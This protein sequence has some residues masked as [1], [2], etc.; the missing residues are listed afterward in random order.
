MSRWYIKEK[1]A[2]RGVH[3]LGV[4]KEFYLWRI[5]DGGI[6]TEVVAEIYD[7]DRASQICEILNKWEEEHPDV[8]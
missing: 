3:A 5:D 6:I 8:V 4:V 7:Q 1:K 2:L